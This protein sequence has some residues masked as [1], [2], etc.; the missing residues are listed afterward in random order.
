MAAAGVLGTAEKK[1]DVVGRAGHGRP[2]PRPR[3]FHV[4]QG[5]L[6]FWGFLEPPVFLGWPRQRVGR[7]AW[8]GKI[9]GDGRPSSSL[10]LSSLPANYVPALRSQI[11][12]GQCLFRVKEVR[13]KRLGKL[14]PKQGTAAAGQ[15]KLHKRGPTW[16]KKNRTPSS[17]AFH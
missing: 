1:R 9:L 6:D 16:R 15:K 2:P 11:Q 14:P 12:I 7:R 13:P 5:G 3:N 10:P 4:E 17:H 8:A